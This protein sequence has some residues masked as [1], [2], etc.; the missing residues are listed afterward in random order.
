MRFLNSANDLP[1][2]PRIRMDFF[3]LAHYFPDPLK[4]R[5]LFVTAPAAQK[6]TSDP[7][8]LLRL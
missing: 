3:K 1:V 8:L 2:K 4:L 7:F 5:I 6:M